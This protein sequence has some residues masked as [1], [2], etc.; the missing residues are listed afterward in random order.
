MAF[1]KSKLPSAQVGRFL[2][3]REAYETVRVRN[4]LSAYF[5]GGIAVLAV[6]G[7]G[8]A[9]FAQIANV[10]FSIP[11]PSL[12]FLPS[13]FTASGSSDLPSGKFNVLI[14]GMGG[15][16]HEG[17]DLTDTVILASLN[18]KTKTVSMLSVPRDLYVEY[19]TGGRGK[20]N[21]TYRRAYTHSGKDHEAAMKTL[22]EK[23]TEITG[24]RVDR[25]INVDFQAFI[26]FVDVLGGL[27]V[28]VPEDLV[29][30][31]YPDSN[32]GYV[33][34]RVKKGKQTFDG[35][36][37]LKYARSRHSTSDFDRSIRQ[38]ILVRAIKEKL[39]SLGTLGNPAKLQALYSAVSSNVQTDLSFKEMAGMALFAKELPTKNILSFNL[40]DSCFQSF[41]LCD[42]GGFLYTP[43]RD[44]FGGASVLLPDGAG[45]SDLSEYRDIQRFA[46]LVFNYPDMFLESTEINV[47]NS[48]KQSGIANKVAL[49]LK[50]F[51]FNVPD[52]E[53]IGSTKDPYPK[54]TVLYPWDAQSK[55]GIDPESATLRA[56]A[57]FVFSDAE[58]VAANKYAK[59]PGAKVEIVLGPDQS[60]FFR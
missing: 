54:T 57:L 35:A 60:L 48:T 38:Q 3:V 58:P 2:S 1:K 13:V 28:D 17:G 16:A 25:T 39:L 44:L 31:E 7:I 22:G 47:V 10:K 56:L 32:W 24:E 52:K 6:L 21:E 5:L 33:T 14:T 29:D 53:S 18:S 4:T 20:I 51:G 8:S 43:A 11:L 12:S 37:A 49:F 40:N 26:R 42:R 19:P 15:A 45:P 55:T 23:V 50:K 36:T 41:A 46:N 30:P 9:A 34:F 59:T 27:D